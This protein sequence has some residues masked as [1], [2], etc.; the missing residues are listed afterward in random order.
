MSD[1]FSAVYSVLFT[2]YIFL[3]FILVPLFSVP[4]SL[5]LGFRTSFRFYMKTFTRL[6][7]LIFGIS[8][9][10][11]G[12]ENLPKKGGFVL[13]ANHPSLLDPF[14]INT[15]LPGEISF[16]APGTTIF[17]KHA[18]LTFRGADLMVKFLGNPLLMSKLI[19]R[20]V[21]RVNGGEPFVL[22]PSEGAIPD[23][24][25]PHIRKTF[26]GIFKDINVP[27]IPV[28][29]QG[30][31]GR[32]FKMKPVR[33]RLS[34]GMPIAKEIVLAGDEKQIINVIFSASRRVPSKLPQMPPVHELPIKPS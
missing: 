9:D 3:Y 26:Y 1:L 31:V 24:S 30:S 28:H 32:G 4:S 27:I 17:G 11:N 10:V 2:S 13:L 33:I 18:V 5:V 29:I 20:L 12:R 8:V 19:M 14:I 15:Y 23:G 34:I 21:N 6:A 25:I 22:F 7:F 16:V